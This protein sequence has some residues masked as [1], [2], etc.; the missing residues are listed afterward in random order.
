MKALG[1]TGLTTGVV[2][3]MLVIR[4]AKKKGK[5]SLTSQE[6]S[7]SSAHDMTQVFKIYMCRACE[8]NFY[9]WI[10]YTIRSSSEQTYRRNRRVVTIIQ[11]LSVALSIIQSINTQRVYMY[12]D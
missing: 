5:A 11:D 10:E 3:L 2:L 6:E 1:I 7:L 9:Q 12:P 4:L 8:G